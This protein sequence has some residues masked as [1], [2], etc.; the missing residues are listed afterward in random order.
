MKMN[1][2]ERYFNQSIINKDKIELLE[3]RLKIN[4]SLYK[5]LIKS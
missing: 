5:N 1:K 2:I 3:N 4:L